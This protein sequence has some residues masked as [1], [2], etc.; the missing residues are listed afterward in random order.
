M[1]AITAKTA[2]ENAVILRRQENDFMLLILFPGVNYIVGRAI[3]IFIF[4]FQ[5][6]PDVI[7]S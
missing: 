7:D 3:C 2:M 6:F 1:A 4:S 5:L